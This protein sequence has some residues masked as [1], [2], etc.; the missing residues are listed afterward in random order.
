MSREIIKTIDLKK[1][2]TIG[3]DR[4]VKSVDG[5]SIEIYEGETF[6]LVG[7][8]GSG[9]STFGK[10]IVGL[11]PPSDGMLFYEGNKVDELS[12][13]EEKRVNREVQMI[14][15]DPQASLNPRMKV[16]DII[17]EGIDANKLAKGKVRKERI[18][19]LLEK[20]GLRPEAAKRYPHEF[21]GG[22]QQRIGIARTLAVQ[23]KFI[24]ADEPISALDVSIQAQILNLLNDLKETEGLTYLFIS[25][26]LSMVKHISDRIGV[27]YLGNIMELASSEDLFHSP[28]HPYTQALLSAIPVPDPARVNREKVMLQGEPPSPENP[29]SGCRFRTRCMHVMD[30][31]SKERPEWREVEAGHWTACHLYTK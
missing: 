29:P 20:V 31:C 12:R 27:M 13:Q 21:S 11:Y 10:T 6:G 2:F 1:H 17:A 8:S 26:D 5:I 18:Y 15:Q 23:P 19:E 25:H 28:K 30:I 4:V 7:E 9:K 3:K 14:F 24:V 22:Q 16:G